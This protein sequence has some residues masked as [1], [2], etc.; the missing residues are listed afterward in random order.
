MKTL[1]EM[2]WR[3]ASLPAAKAMLDS[4]Y[5][6]HEA[7]YPTAHALV[8]SGIQEMPQANLAALYESGIVDL[9]VTAAD[10]AKEALTYAGQSLANINSSDILL[11]AERIEFTIDDMEKQAEDD[12]WQRQQGQA[13]LAKHEAFERN[14]Q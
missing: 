1:N 7:G 2:A 14:C 5:L 11:A 12:W 6:L 13:G 3:R 10:V 9:P 8:L 4:L